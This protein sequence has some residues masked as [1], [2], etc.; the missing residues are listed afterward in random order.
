MWNLIVPVGSE[1]NEGLGRDVDDLH[2]C[3]P[4]CSD[5]V[6]RRMCEHDDEAH[7]HRSDENLEAV[8]SNGTRI[9]GASLQE[10]K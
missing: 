6:L 2:A 10:L 9:S 1:L 8:P 5:L 4:A 3:E 7:E